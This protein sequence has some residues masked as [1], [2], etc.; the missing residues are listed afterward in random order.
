MKRRSSRLEWDNKSNN[1]NNNNNNKNNNNN[2]N[3]KNNSNQD[4]FSLMT[5]ATIVLVRKAIA[6]RPVGKILAI[7]RAIPK[8]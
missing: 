8:H 1:H 2:N 6:T 7:K 3:N 5:T 4:L